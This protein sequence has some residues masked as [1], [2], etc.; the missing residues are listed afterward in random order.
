M[1]RAACLVVGCWLALSPLLS[2]GEVEAHLARAQQLRR[3]GKLEEARAECQAAL[4]ARPHD[5]ETRIELGLVELDLKELDRARGFLEEA[6][7]SSDAAPA[8]LLKIGAGYLRAGLL[9]DAQRHLERAVQLDPT[10][11]RLNL[12][13]GQ[14][15]SGRRLFPSAVRHL[16]QPVRQ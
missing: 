10:L 14:L 7:V 16:E 6:A 2:G 15:Y 1:P 13:L 8:V 12:L 3:E 9:D 5:L 4:R 11:P